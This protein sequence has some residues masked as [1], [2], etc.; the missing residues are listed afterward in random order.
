MVELNRVIYMEPVRV[1]GCVKESSFF[2]QTGHGPIDS[3]SKKYSMSKNVQ[4][5]QA[6][7]KVGHVSDCE[8]PQ[9]DGK[10][11]PI[12]NVSVIYFG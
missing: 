5:V 12:P 2:D 1:R 6:L 9:Q 8:T 7:P 11:L 4:E 10:S 3:S